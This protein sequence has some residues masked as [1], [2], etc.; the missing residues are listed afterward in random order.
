MSFYLT[1]PS[2]SSTKFYTKNTLSNF[3]T[4][5]HSTVALSGDWE[6]GLVEISFPKSWYT[7]HKKI[8]VLSIS[9]KDCKGVEPEFSD[10]G[11]I[12]T[13]FSVEVSIP[14][15][16][17]ETVK[18]V[19]NQL[20][21]NIRKIFSAP[22]K[23]WMTD[24]RNVGNLK[25]KWIGDTHWPS[26]KYNEL[27]RKVY[28]TLPV[29][30][31]II[32]MKELGTLLGFVHKQNPL[33]NNTQEVTTMRGMQ[34]SDIQAGVHSLYIYCDVLEMTPLGDSLVPLL[35]IVSIPEQRHGSII[36]KIYDQIR[37]TPLQKK[38]V[39]SIEID[40]RDSFGEKIAFENGQV[41]VTLHFRRT[42]NPL[43]EP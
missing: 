18:E 10:D 24:N 38:H 29:G 39:D 9:C 14:G 2:N 6:V 1:L 36:N 7:I 22:V 3:T 12:P 31:T 42:R 21:D 37:Y 34:V 35:R 28:C 41:I 11:Y 13:E 5:L 43:F 25:D 32:F 4:R 19:C 33:T 30:T 26:F 40:I 8:S 20:N 23:V 16:Y 15:G 27:N 17:Y